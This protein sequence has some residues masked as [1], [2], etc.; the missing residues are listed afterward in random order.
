MKLA[1]KPKISYPEI[2]YCLDKFQ[3]RLIE[4]TKIYALVEKLTNQAFPTHEDKYDK[5]WEYF[6]LPVRRSGKVIALPFSVM[7]YKKEF[8][9]SF[10]L[11]GNIHIKKGKKET[12]AIYKDIFS[13]AARLIPLIKRNEKILERHVP[14]DFRTGKIKGKYILEKLLSH[15]NKTA[16]L[17]KYE[18]RLKKNLTVEEISLND[19]LK[20]AAICYNA[21]F[22]AKAKN[23][24]PLEMYKKWAD[25]RDNEMLS[26]KDRNSR[27]EFSEWLDTKAHGGGHPF[28]IV[29]SWHGHGI[30]LYPPYSSSPFYRLCV[31]NY[32]YAPAFVK[33]AVALI[34][35][36]IP[37]EAN[38]LKEVLDYLAGETYFTVNDYG[39]HD[40]PYY[41][42]A[43]YKKKYFPHIEWDSVRTLKWKKP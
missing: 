29:F 15:K 21:A 35:E 20:T 22:F 7:E 32:A 9:V 41:P 16:I 31:T 30:H 4:N 23:L 36:K 39:E 6:Y 34:K 37:F 10:H 27:K 42:S 3:E 19:Y 26:I 17:R 8:F 40:F 14:Y 11:L 38:E 18:I 2:E 43:E 1:F 12:E 33:M 25:G 24:S 28:E 13:E 5:R